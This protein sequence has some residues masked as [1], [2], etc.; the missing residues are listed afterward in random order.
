MESVG[1]THGL[2]EEAKEAMSSGANGSSIGGDGVLRG[3][4]SSSSESAVEDSDL[5][6]G[7]AY[8]LPSLSTMRR[9]STTSRIN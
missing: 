4:P 1:G 8:E 5:E 3:G 6:R 7:E 9:R 2:D